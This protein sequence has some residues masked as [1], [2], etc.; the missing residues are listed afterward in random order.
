M[1]SS[2]ALCACARRLRYDLSS[3]YR[4]TLRPLLSV[5]PNY[6]E[7][8][9]SLPNNGLACILPAFSRGRKSE[10]QGRCMIDA[11][12]S[13]L[14]RTHA[15]Q[16]PTHWTLILPKELHEESLT[17]DFWISAG[18]PEEHSQ[19]KGQTSQSCRERLTDYSAI[20][21]VRCCNA[22]R[23]HPLDGRAGIN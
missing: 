21:V 5:Q 9:N 2:F 15:A 13:R 6:L 19:R 8:R 12:V 17:W 11:A 16:L 4:V 18:L 14:P 22:A 3:L 20:E 10:L 1:Q 7:K 23:S